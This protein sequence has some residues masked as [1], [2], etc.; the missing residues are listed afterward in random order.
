MTVYTTTNLRADLDHFNMP[1]SE[2]SKY[3]PYSLRTMQGWLY[4][5]SLPEHAALIL[6]LHFG[7]MS[8]SQELNK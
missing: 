5:D 7:A 6:Q 1:L 2:L 3:V 4:S 8:A